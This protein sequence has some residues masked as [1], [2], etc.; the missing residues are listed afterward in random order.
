MAA[1]KKHLVT[2]LDFQM[3]D[4]VARRLAALQD[5]IRKVGHSRP[6]P[7]TLISALIMNESRRGK[8]L[9]DELLVPHRLGNEDAD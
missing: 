9:E 4:E 5:S 8:Q 3:S 7:R 6:T 2:R 1:P